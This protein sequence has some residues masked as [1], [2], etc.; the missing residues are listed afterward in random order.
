[1]DQCRNIPLGKRSEYPFHT[2][3][4][5]LHAMARTLLDPP[6]NSFCR[7][8]SNEF[9]SDICR[10]IRGILLI[11]D[12]RPTESYRSHEGAFI[13]PMGPLHAIRMGFA[14]CG[15]SIRR[16][17]RVTRVMLARLRCPKR[18]PACVVPVFL[19]LEG[20]EVVVGDG[21]IAVQQRTL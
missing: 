18:I 7:P 14:R 10:G 8:P 12:P 3:C 19:A 13:L 16:F 20:G 21:E 5:P 17:P 9:A 11:L 15:T 6:L 2:R 4:N 1:M